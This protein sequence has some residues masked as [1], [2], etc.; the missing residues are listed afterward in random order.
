[1]TIK[2]NKPTILAFYDNR[3][4]FHLD[5]SAF[6]L[7]M[8]GRV[9]AYRFQRT[10]DG[11]VIKQI[12]DLQL[13][14]SEL[15][16]AKGKLKA[17]EGKSV[18]IKERQGIPDEVRVRY[19]YQKSTGEFIQFELWDRDQSKQ[20]IETQRVINIISELSRSIFAKEPFKTRTLTTDSFMELAPWPDE[21][22][23]P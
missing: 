5:G 13:P 21:F 16:A 23:P 8:N 18:T 3:S 1:M 10:D 20:P 14:P 7:G 11:S 15:E 6:W 19:G 12:F 4:A 17:I 22:T 2:R 9:I